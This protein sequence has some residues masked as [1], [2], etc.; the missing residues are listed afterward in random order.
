MN[1]LQLALI[2]ITLFCAQ[3]L[4]AAGENEEDSDSK[5]FPGRTLYPEISVIE[6]DELYRRLE[7]VIVVD[8]RS[9]Y[10]YETLRIKGA[11]NVPLSSKTFVSRMRQLRMSDPRPIV[12]YCNGKTC[13]KSY[14]AA[15][16]CAVNKIDNVHSYDAGIMD[17]AR[18]YPEHAELLGKSP[19]DPKK[20]ISKKE[21]K[22]HLLSPDAYGEHVANS[23]AIVLDVRDRFQREALSIFVGRERRAYLDD[24]KKLD[25]F[26]EKAM[27]EGKTLLVH[28]A[29]GKQV[30]WLQYYL[31]DKGLKSYYFMD[32]GVAAYYDQ[33]K[34]E[35]GKN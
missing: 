7:E 32:G 11:I 17:W 18:T 10:E 1:S 24:K 12:A 35:F 20:L 8:V 3:P 6:L 21:F 5:E 26:I 25:N 15:R 16:T 34:L 19:V 4:L 28:D 14:K 9:A 22:K 29:A 13:M 2:M 30:Q 31:E 23:S 27:R 33:M